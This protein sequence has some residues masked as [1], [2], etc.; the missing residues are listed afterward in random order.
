MEIEDEFQIKEKTYMVNRLIGAGGMSHVYMAYSKGEEKRDCIAV[1]VLDQE[2]VNDRKKLNALKEEFNIIRKLREH[3]LPNLIDIREFIKIRGEYCLIMPYMA[4]KNLKQRII[5]KEKIRREK[6]PFAEKIRIT[7]EIAQGLAFLHAYNIIHSD[8]KPQNVLFDE[9]GNL[10]LSDFGLSHS[11]S[12]SFAEVVSKLFIFGLF[13]K[14][15]GKGGTPAYMSPQ[16]L[17]GKRSL[18]SDDVY[19]F[20]ILICELFTGAFPFT[21]EITSSERKVIIREHYLARKRDYNLDKVKSKIVHLPSGLQDIILNCLSFKRSE[22]FLD[23]G[24]VYVRLD[25]LGQKFADYPS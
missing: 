2:M 15:G 9:K 7:K 1:K 3:K 16:Q 19:G 18:K 23:M 25:S 8:V 10:S 5:S 12:P 22:R 4:G 13:K 11:L 14:R 6:V 20:G 21:P 17:Q 24:T